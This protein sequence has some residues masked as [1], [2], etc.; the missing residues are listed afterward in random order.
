MVSHPFGSTFQYSSFKIDTSTKPE[1]YRNF[2][3][4]SVVIDEILLFGT[5][6][7]NNQDVRFCGSHNLNNVLNLFFI[8]FKA[9]AKDAPKLV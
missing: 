3:F 9:P 8:L 2:Q 7:T 5:S 6:Q 1:R 4:I